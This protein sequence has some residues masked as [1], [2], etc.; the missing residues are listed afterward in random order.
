MAVS[1]SEQVPASGMVTSLD[2]PVTIVEA[3]AF[4]RGHYYAH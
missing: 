4:S 1:W 3:S 2:C